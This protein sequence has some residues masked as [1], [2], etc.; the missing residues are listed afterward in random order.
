MVFVEHEGREADSFFIVPIFFVL[1]LVG[2]R[3]GV[4]T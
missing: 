1:Y 4:S 3:V 2:A